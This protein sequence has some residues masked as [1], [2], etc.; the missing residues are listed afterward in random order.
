MFLAQKLTKPCQLQIEDLIFRD[1][2]IFGTKIDKIG[3][4]SK[5]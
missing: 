1:H 5:L 2:Y 3:T 4:D